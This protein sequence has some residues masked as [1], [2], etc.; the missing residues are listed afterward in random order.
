MLGCGVSEYDPR[1]PAVDDVII[2]VWAD[3]W[4]LLWRLVLGDGAGC[5]CPE[6]CGVL[7]LCKTGVGFS[8]AGCLQRALNLE[9]I[10]NISRLG[11]VTQCLV[12]KLSQLR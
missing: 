5:W 8:G 9:G 4:Y 1:T 7:G 11:G 12:G 3:L 2:T 10:F 6:D